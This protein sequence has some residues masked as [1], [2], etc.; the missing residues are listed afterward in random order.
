MKDTL[1]KLALTV[2]CL[3]APPAFASCQMTPVT[4]DMP[5]QRLD[6]ALQQLAHQTGCPV[7]VE[8]GADS[9]RKVKKFKGTIT[10]DQALW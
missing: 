4:Y 7:K 3:T 2:A 1:K 6:E 9:S 5:S 8:L 10:P